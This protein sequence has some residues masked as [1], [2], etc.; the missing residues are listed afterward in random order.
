M[1]VK[2]KNKWEEE[3]EEITIER[4]GQIYRKI[5]KNEKIQK[6]KQKEEKL[7]EKLENLLKKETKIGFNIYLELEEIRSEYMVK[8]LWNYYKE[9]LRD[10][11]RLIIENIK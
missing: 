3:I 4:L 11:I 8:L 2:N 7:E 5:V 9:G 10:A 1:N 6:V